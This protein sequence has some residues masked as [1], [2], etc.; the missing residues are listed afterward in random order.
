MRRRVQEWV[1][2]RFD[3]TRY[4]AHAVVEQFSV[5]LRDE[6]DLEDLT[7]GLTR[8][9]GETLRPAGVSLVLVGERV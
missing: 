1:D 7:S 8:L 5:R 9:I 3:R 2:H 4:D 6:V